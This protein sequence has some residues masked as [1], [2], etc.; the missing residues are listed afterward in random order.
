MLCFCV[1]VFF[2]LVLFLFGFIS[3]WFFLLL[4]LVVCVCVIAPALIPSYF[5]PTFH[6]LW[7]KPEAL[8]HTVSGQSNHRPRLQSQ[9]LCTAYK[10]AS[11]LR[12]TPLAPLLLLL[13]A[14]PINPVAT[15]TTTH[16]LLIQACSCCSIS[17]VPLPAPHFLLPA[18]S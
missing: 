8:L 7:T 12:S 14:L 4:V 11:P 17:A 18:A 3:F 9:Q 10:P 13:V 6:S 5:K 16:I 1:C 2:F 15:R